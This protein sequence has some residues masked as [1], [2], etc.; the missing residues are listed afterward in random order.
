MP[1]WRPLAFV[2]FCGLIRLSF[3]AAALPLWE[4]YDEWGHFAVIRATALEGRLLA[5]RDAPVQHDVAA[6]LELAPVPWEL[7]YLPKPALT[8]D[9]FWL[10]TPAER[11]AREL[12]FASMPL[13]WSRE[14]SAGSLTQYEAQHPPLYYWLMAPF[15]LAA[16]SWSLAAQVMLLRFVSLLIASLAIPLVFRIALD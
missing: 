15:L 7:R 12:S 10:L 14:A 11:A 8:Q 6:S 9:D 16:Q 2:W 3:C 4:G 1:A 13:S 5:S